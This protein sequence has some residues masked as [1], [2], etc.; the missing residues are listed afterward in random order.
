MMESKYTAWRKSSRSDGTG[1]GN[2]VE[3]GIASADWRKSSHSGGTGNC[4]EVASA[5]RVIGVRDSKQYGGGPVLEFTAAEWKAFLSETK[6][7]TP[8]ASQ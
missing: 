2:C 5:D 7:S 3:V 8:G 4:V 6:H 1:I